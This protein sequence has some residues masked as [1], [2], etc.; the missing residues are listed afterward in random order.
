MRWQNIF[1]AKRKI[2]ATDLESGIISDCGIGLLIYYIYLIK[3]KGG[4]HG[5]KI[6]YLVSPNNNQWIH[7][8]NPLTLDHKPSFDLMRV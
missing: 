4:G 6:S 5:V 2:R 3:R 1:P 7:C 8:K